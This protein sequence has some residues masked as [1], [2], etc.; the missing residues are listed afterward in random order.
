MYKNEEVGYNPKSTPPKQEALDSIAG[1][2]LG[3]CATAATNAE[4]VCVIADMCA[5]PGYDAAGN[6]GSPLI[7]ARHM[8]HFITLGYPMHLVCVEARPERLQALRMA[9]A[10][11]RP[12]V[13][14]EFY[15]DQ[16]TALNRISNHA[17]GL[18]YWDPTRYNNLDKDLLSAVGRSHRRMDI[19]LTR[20]CLTTRRML[21]APQ[22]IDTL[23]IEEYLALTGK[24]CN[25]V[26]QYAEHGWW[27]LG[28][29]DNWDKRPKAKMGGLVS[30]ETEEGRRLWN[31]V[32]APKGTQPAAEQEAFSWE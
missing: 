18:T 23:T 4:T 14:V 25:Y 16:R 30:V 9:L 15:S 10:T 24:R 19:L 3:A 11:A 13:P 6:E 12:R 31:K 21:N 2:L 28:F 1:H 27:S 29:A 22:C 8:N 7:L 20:E 17:I 32:T 26:W 5:G